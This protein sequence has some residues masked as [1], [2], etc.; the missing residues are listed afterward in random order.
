MSA[1]A[2]PRPVV[3]CVLDGFGLSDDPARNALL[4]A[5]MPTWQRLTAEWPTARLEASG[6]A[7]GLPARQMGNSEVGHLNLGAG[8]PVLQDLPRINAAIADGTFFSNPVLLA[9]ARHALEHGTR[10][11]LLALVGPGGVHAVDEHLLAM[12]ELATR[13]GLRP[14]QVLLHAITDGRDT[15]PRSAAEFLPGL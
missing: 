9:A 3:L 12:V 1:A 13:A 7:V 15:A 11:H 14:D 4:S 8:F 6:Q 2:P 10:V 5:R